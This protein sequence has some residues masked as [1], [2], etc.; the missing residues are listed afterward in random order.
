MCFRHLQKQ[1]ELLWRMIGWMCLSFLYVWNCRRGIEPCFHLDT[2]VSA[3]SRVIAV[4]CLFDLICILRDTMTH[5][6][7]KMSSWWSPTPRSPELHRRCFAWALSMQVCKMQMDLFRNPFLNLLTIRHRQLAAM[8]WPGYYTFFISF[9]YQL[10]LHVPECLGCWLTRLREHQ[11]SAC[12]MSF[13]KRQMLTNRW[14]T[15]I[16]MVSFCETNSMLTPMNTC[17]S[18]KKT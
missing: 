1:L 9:P 15:C 18:L 2:E 13:A 17:T 8:S 11:A 12:Q 16:W 4:F 5:R 3:V 6:G 7:T 14:P 10:A